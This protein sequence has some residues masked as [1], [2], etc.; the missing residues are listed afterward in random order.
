MHIKHRTLNFCTVLENQQLFYF[1]LVVFGRNPLFFKAKD[2]KNPTVANSDFN[3]AFFMVVPHDY[4]SS[5][6]KD[7]TW[8]MRLTKRV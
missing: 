4:C 1:E 5:G 8:H 3:P 6:V 7:E 2:K